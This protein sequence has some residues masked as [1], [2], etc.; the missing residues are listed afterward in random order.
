M[1]HPLRPYFLSGDRDRLRPHLSLTHLTHLSLVVH[2]KQSNDFSSRNPQRLS[3][4]RVTPA[5]PEVLANEWVANFPTKEDRL[6]L[7]SLTLIFLDDVSN[8]SDYYYQV[9]FDFPEQYRDLFD[10]I[11][12]VNLFENPRQSPLPL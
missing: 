6:K 7:T 10:F 2:S 5:S 1:R 12:P 11:N 4:A 3:P 8:Q 9:P